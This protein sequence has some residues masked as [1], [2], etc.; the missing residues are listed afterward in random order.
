MGANILVQKTDFTDKA[1]ILKLQSDASKIMPPISGVLN[2]CMVL[3]D[4]PILNMTFENMER[5]VR[6]KV[7]SSKHMDEIFGSELDFFVFLSSLAAVNGIPGQSNYAA[8]NMY[9]A[10]LAAQRR[11]RGAAASVIH[12]GMIMGVGYVERVGRAAGARLQ[13]YTYPPIPEHEFLQVLGQAVQS[14]SPD[15]SGSPDGGRPEMIIG[16]ISPVKPNGENLKFKWHSNPRYASVLQAGAPVP[17]N[18]HSNIAARVNTKE[19]LA[20][21]SNAAEASVVLQKC[22]SKQLELILQADSVD[23]DLPL[24]QLGLDSLIAVEIRTWFLKEAEVNLPVL[25]IL[26]GVSVVECKISPSPP[27]WLQ[28]HMLTSIKNSMRHC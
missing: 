9:M 27:S 5:A 23:P 1:S 15:D 11:K 14:G 10:S 22:F 16:M 2:G 7:L 17:S 3:D 4:A 13:S 24:A 25:K 28:H 26:S 19:E 20:K 21:T 6:P 18:S 12:L 8:A